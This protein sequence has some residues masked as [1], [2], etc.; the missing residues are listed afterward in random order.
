MVLHAT[1]IE[2]CH[3]SRVNRRRVVTAEELALARDGVLSR[4]ELL[5]IGLD[6]HG[7]AREVGHGRWS[8]L[9]RHT[10][11]VHRGPLTERALWRH[12]LHEVGSRGASMG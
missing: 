1:P 12:A 4:G 8:A 3:G 2:P 6:S 11:V 5:A 9:G 7:V 10:V